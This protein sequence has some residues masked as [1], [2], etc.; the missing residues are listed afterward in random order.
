MFKL[1]NPLKTLKHTK[2]SQLGHGHPDVT[3]QLLLH[4]QVRSVAH[5]TRLDEGVATRL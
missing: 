5:S 1:V 2:G 3:S 4:P